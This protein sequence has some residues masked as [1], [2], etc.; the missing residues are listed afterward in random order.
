MQDQAHVCVCACVW[1][2]APAGLQLCL[3]VCACVTV[4]F[5]VPPE[6]V[7]EY[8]CVHACAHT[9]VHARACTCVHLGAQVS[10]CM[11]ACERVPAWVSMDMSVCS[12]LCTSVHPLLRVG[13]CFCVFK[14]L[15]AHT[16]E[17]CIFS[18]G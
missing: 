7:H 15:C 5:C 18:L 2:C 6:Y 17:C 9:R 3:R 8:T 14:S 16:R 12:H 13:A 1:V 4:H 10:V 11:L